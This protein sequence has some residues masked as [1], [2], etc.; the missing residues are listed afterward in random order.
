ML[1]VTVSHLSGHTT[2]RQPIN[3]SEGLNTTT[4]FSN[5]L[6]F[7]LHVRGRRILSSPL[8]PVS[9]QISRERQACFPMDSWSTCRGVWAIKIM[10]VTT[11]AVPRWKAWWR[12]RGGPGLRWRPPSW[13]CSG[14]SPR[15]APGPAPWRCRSPRRCCWHGRWTRPGHQQWQTRR[16]SWA[17]WARRGP[18]R[19]SSAPSPPLPPRRP[20]RTPPTSL[21]PLSSSP[22]RASCPSSSS[23][24][25]QHARRTLLYPWGRSSLSGLDQLYRMRRE[26]DRGGSPEMP[27]TSMSGKS[28]RRKSSTFWTPFE[29]MFIPMASPVPHLNLMYRFFPASAHFIPCNLA[30]LLDLH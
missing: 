19:W 3:W 5:F 1:K 14:S 11:Y 25:N 23:L 9:S 7:Q 21:G 12:R 29:T 17:R 2:C 22:P 8:P 27:M 26:C 6:V 10:V 18:G 4:R 24:R 28:D 30:N 15:S 13:W 16:G 20:P